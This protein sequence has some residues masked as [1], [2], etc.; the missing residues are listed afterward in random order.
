MPNTPDPPD[1]GTLE[2]DGHDSDGDFH[3]PDLSK[4]DLPTPP[5]GDL[6]GWTI[7]DKF[8]RIL[9][10]YGP[11]PKGPIRDTP[12]DQKDAGDPNDAGGRVDSG[13][14]QWEPSHGT[15]VY[16]TLPD[17]TQME[18]PGDDFEDAETGQPR[19]GRDTWRQ[20]LM[21][22]GAL[23]V[24]GVL[25]ALI[26]LFNG[27]EADTQTS[28]TTATTVQKSDE[29]VSAVSPTD[30]GFVA[31]LI[32]CPTGMQQDATG[33]R[34]SP[35]AGEEAKE[36]P[37]IAAVTPADQAFNLQCSGF[38]FGSYVFTMIVEGNAE[39]V[40][41]TE[42]TTFD[43]RFVVNNTWPQ[44]VYEDDSGFTVFV[45]WNRPAQVYVGSVNDSSNTRIQDATEDIVWLDP[46]TLQATVTLP[47]NDIDVRNVRTE[48]VGLTQDAQEVTTGQY[49][50]VAIWT[51][52]P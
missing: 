40:S 35:R 15:G 17:G 31:A 13:E 16:V 37:E 32:D 6:S 33:R 21:I 52:E 43:L 41:K 19:P 46:S 51:T 39:S 4:T 26:L 3:K 27:G 20:A 29:P 47:G 30:E 42:G 12:K 49:F 48:L 24:L 36:E 2:P 10:P 11:K 28:D 50:D 5:K 7:I 22:G 9:L 18:V 25:A 1:Y 45:G 34:P 38:G 23:G 14:S 44:N 8:R